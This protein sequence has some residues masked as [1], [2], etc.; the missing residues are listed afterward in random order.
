VKGGSTAA[1][2]LAIVRLEGGR[3][4]V[5]RSCGGVL[6]TVEVVGVDGALAFAAGL[7]AACGIDRAAIDKALAELAASAGIARAAA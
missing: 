6:E 2:T 1:A 5:A 3:P 4:A 7:L